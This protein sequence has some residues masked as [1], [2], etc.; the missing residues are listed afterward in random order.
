MCLN[1]SFWTYLILSTPFWMCKPIN[2]VVDN[3]EF[4]SV[5]VLSQFIIF[6]L[7]ILL[8]HSFVFFFT[9]LTQ[10]SKHQFQHVEHNKI[11]WDSSDTVVHGQFCSLPTHCR[12]IRVRVTARRRK[13]FWA[14]E[15]GNRKWHRSAWSVFL[16]YGG[17]GRLKSLPP[18][19]R[20]EAQWRREERDRNLRVKGRAFTSRRAVA[21][22]CHGNAGY[23][24]WGF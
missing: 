16:G 23:H 12:I 1:W 4:R 21:I 3:L 17:Q 22:C 9:Y 2:H 5:S 15:T 18:A 14:M 8:R 20:E 7:I 6:C 24:K 10:L 11:P 13:C 19:N